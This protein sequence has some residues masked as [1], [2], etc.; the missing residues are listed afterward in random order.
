MIKI[1]FSI[2]LLIGITLTT[3]AQDKQY[4]VL[5]FTKT[6][7][8][9]HVS[10]H[11]GVEAIRNM[12]E[13]HHFN[14]DWHVDAKQFN[15]RKLE[16]YQAVI[17][18]NNTGDVINEEQQKAMEDF[19]RSGK[20]FVGIHS[21][22][23]TEYDW[24]WYTKMVGRMFKIHPKIQTAKLRVVD[25]KFPGME[26]TPD[27][28]VWTDEWYQYGEE[29]IDD[30]QY[31]ITVDEK[32]FDPKVKWG[33]NVGEGMGDFHPL[34]WYHNYDGGRAYYTGLGHVPSTYSDPVF[35]DQ[36]AGA[37]WWAATGKGIE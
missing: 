18:L 29:K 4:N 36:L 33:D 14:F 16:K 10:I 32:S 34:V 12:G 9:H 23:D 30:L 6:V 22:S 19:I 37:I 35:L 31:L 5:L 17:Y 27:A 28:R 21:A 2:I 13:R 20:G 25:K 15:E 24:E 8:F 7:G 26:T 11:E 1:I 3:A